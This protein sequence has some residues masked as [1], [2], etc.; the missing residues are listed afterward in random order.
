MS[1]CTEVN[2]NPN[3]IVFENKEIDYQTYKPPTNKQEEEVL[4]ENYP[5][6]PYFDDEHYV[7]LSYVSW[8]FLSVFVLTI[9][10]S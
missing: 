4:A 8:I 6:Y 5:D 9:I 7:R 10:F 1:K 2:T 3:S